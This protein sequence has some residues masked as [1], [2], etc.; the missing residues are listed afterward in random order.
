MDFDH[1]W[2]GIGDIE[3]AGLGPRQRVILEVAV[4]ALD[5]AGLGC[6]APGSRA[7]VV[8]GTAGTS[9]RTVN[10]AH[11]LSK[12]LDLHGPSLMVDS[13]RASPLV[14][15]DTA[16]RLLAD[17]SVPFVIAGGTNLI[18]LPDISGIEIP[19][20]RDLC[21][22]LVLQRSTDTT[23]RRTRQYAQI[24][25]SGIGFPA[26][27]DLEARIALTRRNTAG[28]RDRLDPASPQPADE[29]PTLIPLSGRDPAA[30]HE[31]ARRWADAVGSAHS[32]H[33]FASATARLT[34]EPVRA[35]VLAHD[36][37][38]AKSLLHAL[39]QRI[40]PQAT[41]A[42]ETATP[43]TP[44]REGS[45]FPTG[46][47][48]SRR[49]GGGDVLGI[50]A[51]RRGGG[52]LFLFSGG[53]AHPQ[54]GRALA[55]RYPV[56][57]GALAAAADAIAA[58]GGMRVW[59]P[60]SGFEVGAAGVDVSQPAVFAFE[61]A[62]AELLAAWGVRPD[63]VAGHG[64]GEIAAAV[65]GGALSL[66]DAAR[67]VV[68]RGRILTLVG[69]HAAAAV[70]EATPAEA[71]RLVEPMREVIG[72]AAVDGPSSITVSG[73]P[74]YIDAL[75]RRAHRRAIFAQRISADGPA[76]AV[77]IPRMRN[78]APQLIMDLAGI[79]ALTPALP[80]Y[81]TT[82][83]GALIGEQ[84]TAP[85]R[86]VRASGLV[87]HRPGANNGLGGYEPGANSGLVGYEPGARSGLVGYEPGTR[88]GRAGAA[89]TGAATA[90]AGAAAEGSIGVRSVLRMDA[91]YWGEHAAGPVELAA[92]LERAAAEGISTVLEIAPHPVLAA[93]LREH[94]VF[95]EASYPVAS[96]TDESGDFLRAIARLYLDGRAIDWTALG[97]HT[98]APPQRH[99]RSRT[100]PDPPGPCFPS[101]TI[102][103]EGTYVVAGGLGELGAAAV[104]W[105][106]DS[107]AR[108]VVVLARVPRALPPPLEGL[109]D[110]I[111][112]VRCDTGDRNDLAIALQD[113]R[114]FGVPI[115]GVVH[116]IREPQPVAASNLVELTDGDPTDFTV[117]CA[118][119][120]AALVRALTDAHPRRRIMTAG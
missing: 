43:A 66:A 25:D 37:A 109:E 36:R 14:A 81:S 27:S 86:D 115:R 7:G 20:D 64:V 29:P 3:A 28:S 32:L 93:V 71:M 87:G 57:A 50:S 1:D 4:E 97:P 15:V 112:V 16:M 10:S 42:C 5:D 89:T 53:G 80:I 120:G 78:I 72:V 8:F 91:S 116:A 17:E 21:T 31:L 107:G 41:P 117:V 85:T 11:Q 104:G 114:E 54:M 82:R 88:S 65:T 46:R 119:A 108:D 73:E 113:I 40:D 35:A 56:F 69:N 38:E 74:R 23:H 70:L 52:V 55:A 118:P 60:H 18:L 103:P 95:R 94:P 24:T 30:V 33:E 2:F 45:L 99:W 63:A 111:V 105:L 61:L 90:G 106:L 110:R 83:R 58:A 9:R 49:P 13:D 44:A 34:P 62:L 96:R 77:H 6:L 98:A 101:V 12:A 51:G 48:S 76:A 100:I 59:Y 68:A 19:G 67:I 47:E 92:A 75:V 22:V 84:D 39:T 102:R 26:P 79:E